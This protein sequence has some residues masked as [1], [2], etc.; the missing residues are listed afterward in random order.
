MPVVALR[1]FNVYGPRQS[2]KSV[3]AA[4]IPKFIE[5]MKVG[6]API[7]FGDGK[8][9]R[10]FVFIADV[11]RANMLAAESDTAAGRAINICSGSETSLLDLLDVLRSIIPHAPDPEFTET[12]IGDLPRSIG[13]P[14]LAEELLGFRA[15]TALDQ[16]LK[17]C[18]TGRVQ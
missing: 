10:D 6:Q 2:P 4:V 14:K 1:Y 18:V 3:Y 5:W 12:R 15:Q 16:G 9:T 13:S 8:Q 17:R 7:V 11:V